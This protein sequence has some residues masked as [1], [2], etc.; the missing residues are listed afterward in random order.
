MTA[1]QVKEFYE[2][3]ANMQNEEKSLRHEMANK[4]QNITLNMEQKFEKRFDK[5]ETLISEGFDKADGKFATKVEHSYNSNRIEKIEDNISRVVWTIL[6]WV[7]SIV[8]AAVFVMIML[9]WE[10]F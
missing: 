10:R 8:W 4:L 1:L 2:K 3:L 9:F 7:I 6:I 5:L